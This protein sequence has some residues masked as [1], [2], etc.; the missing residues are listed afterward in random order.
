MGRIISP[1][2]LSILDETRSQINGLNPYV[3]SGNNP[4]MNVDPSC[5]DFWKSLCEIII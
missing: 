1:D 2:E 4:V 5:Q 3:Y